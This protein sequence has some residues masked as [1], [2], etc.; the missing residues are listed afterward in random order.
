MHDTVVFIICIL[1]AIK[2]LRMFSSC[3]NETLHLLNSNFLSPQPLSIP[4]GPL[5]LLFHSL[6]SLN[7][8][9]SWNHAV[10]VF[11]YNWLI[12]LHV[13]S[14]TLNFL[15]IIFI[16]LANVTMQL[17]YHCDFHL[18][19]LDSYK[20]W[21]HFCM[22]VGHLTILPFYLLVFFL[23]ICGSSL[24]IPLHFFKFIV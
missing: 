11:L 13:I 24:Y 18:Y 10:F 4:R 2:S 22:L 16:I 14:S 21:I 15:D 17:A 9:Y 8:S 5:Y 3:K 6:I 12:S 19:F 23:L 1:L 20:S 7:T